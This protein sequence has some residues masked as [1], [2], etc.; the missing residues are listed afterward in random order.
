MPRLP[1][2]NFKPT[3]FFFEC[4]CNNCEWKELDKCSDE[5]P[6]KTWKVTSELMEKQKK[7]KEL[8]N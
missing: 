5:T 7:L 3:K 6:C 2:Y 1:N 4:L 8:L